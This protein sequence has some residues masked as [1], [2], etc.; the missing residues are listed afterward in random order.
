M[1]LGLDAGSV[2]ATEPAVA[3]LHIPS[4]D[5]VTRG[6][7]VDLLHASTLGWSAVASLARLTPYSARRVSRSSRA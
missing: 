1:A 3:D 2:E 6:L 4:I 7:E 5:D